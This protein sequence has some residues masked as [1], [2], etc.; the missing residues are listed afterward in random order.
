MFGQGI[1]IFQ[2][3]LVWNLRAIL[4]CSFSL[5]LDVSPDSSWANE[6]SPWLIEKR[7]SFLGCWA[8]LMGAL[9]CRWPPCLPENEVKPEGSRDER[10]S[11]RFSMV[12]SETPH[13]ALPAARPIP[14]TFQFYE[15]LNYLFCFSQIFNFLSLITKGV[16]VILTD[17]DFVACLKDARAV[18]QWNDSRYL[19][20]V[21]QSLVG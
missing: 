4:N 6:S 10:E 18:W 15:L 17:R 16:W 7:F 11:R 9:S 21:I 19:R 14:W 20:K 13:P 2:C 3:P 8:E 1:T 12:T 5:S